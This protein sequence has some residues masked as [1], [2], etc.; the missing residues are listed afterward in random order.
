MVK[1][2][3]LLGKHKIPVLPWVFYTK[4][5]ASFIPIYAPWSSNAASGLEWGLDSFI[6]SEASGPNEAMSETLE[7]TWKNGFLQGL[8]SRGWTRLNK[9]ASDMGKVSEMQV[10]VLEYEGYRSWGIKWEERCKP[11]LDIWW[12]F[13]RRSWATIEPWAQNEFQQDELILK[14]SVNAV[15]EPSGRVSSGW[16]IT[17]A[18]GYI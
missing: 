15:R 8:E 14:L 1:I 6:Y 11:L 7:P 16:K 4:Y 2:S 18:S 17:V 3:V 10:L 9:R 5:T 13:G 12:C